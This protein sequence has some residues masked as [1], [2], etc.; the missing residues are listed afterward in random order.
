MPN[1]RQGQLIG[2]AD[3]MSQK[4]IEAQAEKLGIDLST[5]TKG[6]DLNRS[7]FVSDEAFNDARKV[8]PW[9]VQTISG[10]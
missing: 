2:L 10:S 4:S 3:K 6:E 5:V 7:N 9:A 1:A 8:C